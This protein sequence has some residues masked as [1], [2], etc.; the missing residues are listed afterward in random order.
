MSEEKISKKKEKDSQ[1]TVSRRRFLNIVS[2]S[3][4]SISA[5]GAMGVTFEYLSPNVVLEMPSEFIFGTLES[6]QPNSTVFDTEHRIFIFRDSK[7]FFYVL[8]AVCTHLGCTST[9]KPDG[10]ADHPEGVI[11]CPCH[12]SVFSKTGEV[13]KGPAT[14]ALDRYR[15]RLEDG[16]LIVDMSETVSEEE[17]ILKV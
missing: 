5:L 11:A 4:L 6:M 7:G 14:V 2:N 3:A 13:L 12:G 8:S 15:I 9:W 16:K 17:M 1:N 10:I